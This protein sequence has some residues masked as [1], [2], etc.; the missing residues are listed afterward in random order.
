MEGSK[1]GLQKWEIA[2][3]M[4]ATNLKSISSM[5]LYRE[6][7]IDSEVCMVHAQS[8]QNVV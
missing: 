3:Y 8:H 6:L 2:I 7:G 1:I 5:K 4:V